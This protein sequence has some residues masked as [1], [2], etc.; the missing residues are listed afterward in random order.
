M[1]GS[2]P[3]TD[4]SWSTLSRAGGTNDPLERSHG[5]RGRHWQALA[6][7]ATMVVEPSLASNVGMFRFPLK[8]QPRVS[9]R[10]HGGGGQDDVVQAVRA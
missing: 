10:R 9:M 5:E 6:G 3:R 7:Q 4:S 8:R 1:H 2:D